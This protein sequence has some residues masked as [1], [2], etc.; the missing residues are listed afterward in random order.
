MTTTDPKEVSSARNIESLTLETAK[1]VA[2]E[3]LISLRAYAFWQSRGCTHGYDVEDWLA[4]E[5]EIIDELLM[6]EK[7]N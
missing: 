2:R 1:S 5:S 3:K 7:T 6:S 4:A